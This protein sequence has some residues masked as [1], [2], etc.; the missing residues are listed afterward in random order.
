MEGAE[1]GLNTGVAHNTASATVQPHRR[2]LLC[3]G[4]PQDGEDRVLTVLNDGRR[5]TNEVLT[6]IAET[7]DLIDQRSLTNVD[8]EQE[9]KES[10]TLKLFI[11]FVGAVSEERSVPPTSETEART[12]GPLQ[13]VKTACGQTVGSVGVRVPA[14]HQPADKMAVRVASTSVW[15]PSEYN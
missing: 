15:R 12:V 9:A 6:T 2:E 11:R 8:L 7:E 10:L 14:I 5:I 13:A 3:Y 1:D 4:R